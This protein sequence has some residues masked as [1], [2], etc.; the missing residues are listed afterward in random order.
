MTHYDVDYSTLE[1]E[2]KKAK[3]LEDIKEWLGEKKFDEV[4]EL[5]KSDESSKNFDKFA[6]YCG[7]VGVQYYPVEAW[8]EEI[9]G[10]P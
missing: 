6:F 7:L 3:A 9:H 8:F 5:L 2:A 4:T 1:G 10:G